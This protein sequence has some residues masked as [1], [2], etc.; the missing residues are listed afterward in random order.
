MM[1]LLLALFTL[2]IGP[3]ARAEVACSG[4]LSSPGG[5]LSG[6]CSGNNCSA[7]LSGGYVSGTGTCGAEGTV[8]VQGNR[9]GGFVSGQCMGSSISLFLPSSQLLLEGR[10]PSGGRFSGQASLP[11]GF[12]SGTCTE[13]GG[14]HVFVP[15]GTAFFRGY[16]Q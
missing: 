15:G 3:V 1:K 4:Q 13:N 12:V 2:S 10:C 8:Q 16:C 5:F 14:F 9:P 6:N 7:F 11:G